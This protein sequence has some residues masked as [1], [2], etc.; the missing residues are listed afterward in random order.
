[1]YAVGNTQLLWSPNSEAELA[2]YRIYRGTTTDFAVAPSN[3]LAAL[4][5]STTSYLDAAGNPY[6]YKLTAVDVHGNESVVSTVVPTGTT[7]VE[8]A[9]A[10][11]L[12]IA[13][14]NPNPASRETRVRFSL[15]RAGRVSLAV[16]DANGRRAR[17]LADGEQSAGTH[18]VNWNLRQTSGARVSAGLYFVR[19]TTAEG[20]L[21][22]RLVA[23]E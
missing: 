9:A 12:A 19:L 22:R 4:G 7:G 3:L 14:P 2:G 15:P 23:L 20:T 18:E 5:T 6:V 8:G 13:P 1:L 21:V 17:I 16:Y 11:V 10:P